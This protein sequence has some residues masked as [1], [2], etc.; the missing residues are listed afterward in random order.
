MSVAGWVDAPAGKEPTCQGMADICSKPTCGLGI[1]EA[2]AKEVKLR[3]LDVV[4]AQSESI[5]WQMINVAMP[6][7]ILILGVW[8]FNAIRRRRYAN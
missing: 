7:L 5:K 1:I 3:M 4:R 2:R 6:L 8:G